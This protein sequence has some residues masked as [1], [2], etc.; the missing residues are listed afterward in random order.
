MRGR[1]LESVQKVKHDEVHVTIKDGRDKYGIKGNCKCFKGTDD[2]S[3]FHT[4]Y[5]LAV[6]NNG[7]D[8]CYRAAIRR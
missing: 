7:I 3:H 2:Q 6:M 1:R 8:G 5:Y 4:R